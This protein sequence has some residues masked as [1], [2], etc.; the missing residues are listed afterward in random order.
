MKETAKSFPDPVTLGDGAGLSDLP[1]EE[2]SSEA[3][4]AS[5]ANHFMPF[6]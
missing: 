4:S 2:I 1:Q 3:K 5:E 6:F